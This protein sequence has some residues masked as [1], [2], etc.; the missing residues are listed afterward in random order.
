MPP[1]WIQQA[2]VDFLRK[3]IKQILGSSFKLCPVEIK[4]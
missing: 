4:T 3:T 2:L 1:C